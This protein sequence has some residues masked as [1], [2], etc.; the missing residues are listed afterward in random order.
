MKHRFRDVPRLAAH[1]LAV[2]GAMLAISCAMAPAKLE[3]ANSPGTSPFSSGRETLH[4]LIELSLETPN[5]GESAYALAQMVE[6]W[7]RL[8]RKLVSGAVEPDRNS[9]SDTTFRVRFRVD[10]PAEFYPYYFDEI[11][12]ALDY[13]VKK[14]ERHSKEGIGAPLKALRENEGREP[15]EAWYPP[16][17]I[18]REVTAVIHPGPKQ[19]STQDITIELLCA[20]YHEYVT[21]AGTRQPLAAEYTVALAGLLERTKG[22]SRAEFWDLVKAQPSRD[23][24]LYLMEPYDPRKEPLIMIHGLLASPLTWADLTNALRADPQIR[25]RYQVWH[26]LYNTSAPAL[27]SGRLLRTQLR[28]LRSLLDPGRRHAAS[29]RSTLITH[30]MGGIVARG[31]IT[32]PG[33][34]FWNAAFTRPFSS[35]NLGPED[36]DSLQEA[37]F[38]KPDPSVRRVVFIAVPHRGSD[39]A[40]NL[41]GRFGR[42]IV[43][44]PRTFQAFYERISS[45]NPGAFTEAYAELGEG[46]LDSVSA[47]SPLQPT[48]K[49]LP[50]LPLGYRVSLHSIIG[51]QG[52]EGELEE[53]S[54]GI[55]PYWSSHLDEAATE[56]ILPFGHSLIDEPDT[57][58]EISRLLKLP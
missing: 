21:V 27:Y 33:D 29:H 36:R 37:F 17:A 19:G 48:L 46:K 44:P 47:L 39:Y 57:T 53:S 24:Q 56:T 7:H 18:T 45:A 20:H 9:E 22:L 54:D 31:L 6:E 28:D 26:Y 14:L 30:S 25:S 12:P 15:I 38:W 41:V 55:V 8:Q 49:I 42:S 51:D 35:L 40:D 32:E 11:S 52:K 4:G 5:E 43:K 34:A 50:E 58:E 2:L 23:P 1:L 16:E 13:E 3:R 10:G